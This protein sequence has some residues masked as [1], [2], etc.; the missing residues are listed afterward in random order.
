MMD[1]EVL[2]SF[3]LSEREISVYLALLSIGS[4]TT[5]PLIKK[6]GI[7]NAKIYETLG[8]L[9]NRGLVNY[10][11]KGKVKNF[12]A[13]SPEVL[14]KI[15]KERGQKLTETITRLKL[16][17]KQ[18]KPLCEAKTY[19]G[20]KAIKYLFFQM[21]EEIGKNSEY[22]VFPLG[23][24]LITEKL[25]LFWSEILK[26]QR[27]MKIKIKTMPNEKYRNIFEKHYSGLRDIKIR[28]TK[29]EFP[30][31]IFIFDEYVL[32]IMWEELPIAFLIKSKNNSDKWKNL[33]DEQWLI[34]SKKPRKKTNF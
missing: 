19:E 29:M 28:Y 3:G 17:Y 5:G 30:A 31:G 8:K 33:F 25:I 1:K 7:Q 34:S 23:K 22:R 14:L 2:K 10:T 18:N 32:Q 4:T 12:Q 21:Y 11:Y 6:S 13:C 27:K 26:L 20:V 15:Y 16:L 24:E 9:I